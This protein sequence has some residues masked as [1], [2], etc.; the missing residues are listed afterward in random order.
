[1]SENFRCA[2][3]IVDFSNLVSR[4][5][6]PYG[7]VPFCPD[8]E[9]IFSAKTDAECPVS[10]YLV[11]KTK[12]GMTEEEFTA[13]KIKE[14]IGTVPFGEK[15]LEPDDFAI[16]VPTNE[17]GKAYSKA[18]AALG[19]PTSESV[20]ENLS[21]A[22][23]VILALNILRAVDNPLRDGSL[24]GM[25]YSSVF[26]FSLDDLV[27]IRVRYPDGTFYSAVSRTAEDDAS[28]DGGLRSRCAAF[29]GRLNGYRAAE[30]SSAANVFV[31]YVLNECGIL[32]AP[33]VTGSPD[34]A[35]K[36]RALI[37]LSRKY[38]DGVFGGLYGFLSYI[39]GLIGADKLTYTPGK[40]GSVRIMTIHKSKGL[41]F[42]VC[43]VGKT[44]KAYSNT[45]YGKTLQFDPELGVGTM[46]PGEGGYTKYDTPVR[47]AIIEKKRAED[48]EERMRLLYVAMTRAKNKLIITATCDPG[49]ERN[50]ALEKEW[51]RDRSVV[52]AATRPLDH[53]L[54]AAQVSSPS[55]CETVDVSEE[56]FE[57]RGE[58]T[59]EEKEKRAAKEAAD[60][61]TLKRI[62]ENFA[63]EYPFSFLSNLPS[64]LA[65][66]KLYP[67]A[68]DEGEAALPE[69]E[70]F[71]LSDGNMPYPTFMTGTTD[72]SPADKGTA[73]HVF[74]QFCDFD[75]LAEGA[76]REEIDRLVTEGFMT[77]KMAELV[78]EDF[79]RLFIRG[80][81]FARMR[82]AAQTWREFRFNVRLPAAQFTA[83]AG[84]AE[85]LEKANAR[86]T[87]QGVFDC[88]FREKDGTLVLV[89]YKTDAMTSY[90]RSHPEVFAEKLRER[91]KAQLSYYREAA[92][93]IFGRA[94][95]ETLIWSLAMGEAVEIK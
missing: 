28:E 50:A 36:V 67:E 88:V 22:P 65:V 55:V 21:E 91:H 12:D 95:D 24:A 57:I 7:N 54:G 6:F 73:N 1:M 84:L 85:K 90:E 80:D 82:N 63:F 9:L 29:L 40:T 83:D 45:E 30:R 48:R 10:V 68:L 31:E 56:G 94:P 15:P 34:G 44:D 43:I 41:E 23:E 92:A 17:G 77:A 2:R 46:L 61:E 58:E 38:E 76:V 11:P 47:R 52:M 72:Y 39:D 18:L 93:L 64:K 59:P 27:N 60:S 16:L 37:D 71:D 66:S 4:R 49:K 79:I 19:I 13:K 78:E 25:M 35:E 20:G 86:V 89:D 32:N 53:V 70:E 51:M 87:V 33:E 8:D 74:M 14:M 81:L 42:S 69:D 3:P 75:R 62:E 26:G 5:T